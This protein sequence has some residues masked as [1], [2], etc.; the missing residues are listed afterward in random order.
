MDSP[1]QAN[2][3]DGPAGIA[4][5]LTTSL[6]LELILAIVDVAIVQNRVDN[7]YWCLQ[8]S[9]VSHTIRAHVLPLAY[10]F[11]LLKTTERLAGS[12]A[13]WNGQT[14]K[15]SQSAFLS[16]L[17]HDPNAHPRRHIKH[18]VFTSDSFYD[19][20][21]LNWDGL[22][23]DNEPSKQLWPIEQLTC[24]YYGDMMGLYRA[25][26]QPRKMLLVNI[27][28]HDDKDVFPH[29]IFAR[30]LFTTPVGSH[31]QVW[32]EEPEKSE[33]S[34][35]TTRLTQQRAT[36]REIH[37]TNARPVATTTPGRDSAT[38]ILT[39]Q[40]CEGDYLH[41]FPDLFLDGLEDV[42]QR[43]KADI[44]LAC[45]VDYRVTGQTVAELIHGATQR[46]LPA[47][48]INGRLRISHKAWLPRDIVE[49]L[50]A[51][52]VKAELRGHDPWDT[53]R[54]I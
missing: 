30:L 5:N 35:F 24:R 28:T 37:F 54:P 16:W 53:G 38:M 47:E 14:H 51:T 40:L 15:H 39:I 46:S 49:D 6:P 22:R 25:G 41:H 36:R 13:G 2:E 4:I 52:L 48:A 43:T 45:N 18:L 27:G 29:D 12:F 19:E 44:V 42:L 21:D 10:D 33:G 31:N 8:L 26:L 20:D 50:F 11:I 34:G 3:D 9:L 17:L 7:I 32:T 1:A 23:T